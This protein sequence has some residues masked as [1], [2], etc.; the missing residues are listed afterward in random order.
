M[1]SGLN[2]RLGPAEFMG[3]GRD[4]NLVSGVAFH[5]YDP[6]SGVIEVSAYASDGAW[7]NRN[8]V[9]EIFDYPFGQLGVRIC[10]ARIAEDN[11]KA[12]R[13]WR[14]LG[15]AEYLIADLWAD[16]VA[17]CVY[18]LTRDRWLESRFVKGR[19]AYGQKITADA[20]RSAPARKPANPHECADR[21]CQSDDGRWGSDNA[22]GIAEAGADRL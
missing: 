16:G 13:I 6:K 4:G 12:R 2:L 14:A 17:E 15:A 20:A 19:A 10:A 7:L 1:E 11:L 3:W 22:V 21:R 5:N 18:I 9:C 8:R